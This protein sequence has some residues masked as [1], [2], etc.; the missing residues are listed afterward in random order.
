MFYIIIVVISWLNFLTR[1]ETFCNCCLS[2]KYRP[3]I[4]G[5]QGDEGPI[6]DEGND[7]VVCIKNKWETFQS[8]TLNSEADSNRFDR[9]LWLKI[10]SRRDSLSNVN[11]LPYSFNT[12][13]G[14]KKNIFSLLISS[15]GSNFKLCFQS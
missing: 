12:F 13:I 11:S 6:Q 2:T 7:F 8:L 9:I 3:G 4:S 10:C 15:R 5:I 14:N 1:N